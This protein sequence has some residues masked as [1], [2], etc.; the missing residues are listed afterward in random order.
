MIKCDVNASTHPVKFTVFPYII[1]AE[2]SFA[3]DLKEG[4]LFKGGDN[5]RE[6]TRVSFYKSICLLSD[7]LWNQVLSK[8]ISFFFNN[9]ILF[10]LW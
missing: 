5:L 8:P 1:S 3:L 2:T 9:S 6:E 7:I 10:D 4:K